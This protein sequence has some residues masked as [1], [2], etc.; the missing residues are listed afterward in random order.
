MIINT[1][2]DEGERELLYMVVEVEI[3]PTS[4]EIWMH[5]IQNIKKRNVIG[6]LYSFYT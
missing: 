1:A 4:Q 5:G 6:Q 2:K 3:C